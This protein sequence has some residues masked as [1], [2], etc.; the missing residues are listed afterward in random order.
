MHLY[1]FLSY[2]SYYAEYKERNI[3]YCN[4]YINC[5]VKVNNVWLNSKTIVNAFAHVSKMLRGTEFLFHI[6]NQ[7]LKIYQA[8][9]TIHKAKRL[10]MLTSHN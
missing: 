6:W 5:N 7:W 3:Y 1:T 9:A 2:G 4:F 8:S 10:T